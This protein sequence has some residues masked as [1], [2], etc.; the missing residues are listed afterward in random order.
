[1][2]Y[3]KN[4]TYDFLCFFFLIFKITFLNFRFL[5]INL[6]NELVWVDLSKKSI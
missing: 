3:L 5:T 2:Y 1:M 6:T 4:T